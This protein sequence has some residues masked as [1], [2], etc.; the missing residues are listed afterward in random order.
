MTKEQRERYLR[1]DIHAMRVKNF[2]WSEDD[3]KGLLKY[4]A[5]LY[6]FE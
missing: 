6:H 2:K 3:L 5:Q 4:L 1:Q